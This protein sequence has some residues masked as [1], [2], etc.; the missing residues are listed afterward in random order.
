MNL[1]VAVKSNFGDCKAQFKS[2]PFD[3]YEI[4]RIESVSV[5]NYYN[6]PSTQ[7]VVFVDSSA[8]SHNLSYPA[9]NYTVST[10]LTE[11]CANMTTADGVLTYT[12]SQTAFTDVWNIDA[13]AP[14]SFQLTLPSYI[15]KYFGLGYK[16][17]SLSSTTNT[18]ILGVADFTR[19]RNYFIHSSQEIE[20]QGCF[21]GSSTTKSIDLQAKSSVIGIVPTTGNYFGTEFNIANFGTLNS[22]FY[23]FLIDEEGVQIETSWTLILWL[24][25]AA[26]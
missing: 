20:G 19:T 25:G 18:I 14:G 8:V 4:F 23:L 21:Y 22:S 16:S 12:Q 2:I 1:R 11:L 10:F 6:F 15:S 24:C 9:G 17:N 5:G 7:V 3:G 26:K 13:S